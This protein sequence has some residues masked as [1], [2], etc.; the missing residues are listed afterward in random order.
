V[1]K[2]AFGAAAECYRLAAHSTALPMNFGLRVK[3]HRLPA[4]ESIGHGQDARATPLL[5]KNFNKFISRPEEAPSFCRSQDKTLCS[6]EWEG[7]SLTSGFCEK[8]S[9]WHA[10]SK[11]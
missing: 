9:T 1:R 11:S 8:R 7:A 10:L 4:D 3:W 6:P 5:P 2:S